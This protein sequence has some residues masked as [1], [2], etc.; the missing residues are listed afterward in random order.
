MSEDTIK[1]S[2]EVI[3]N[4]DRRTFIAK[5]MAAMAAT[6]AFSSTACAAVPEPG[7]AP[8]GTAPLHP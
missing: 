5:A 7:A 2:I 8:A 3:D 4:E 6:S 1:P